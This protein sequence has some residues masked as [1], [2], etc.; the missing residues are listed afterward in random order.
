MSSSRSFSSSGR[1]PGSNL[2]LMDNSS[3]DPREIW[4][5][6]YPAVEAHLAVPG[7]KSRDR[8]AL[9]VPEFKKIA[10]R[11]WPAA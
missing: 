1:R 8:G 5:A 7:S 4:E 10:A 3:F 2:I 6:S 11:I 9:G